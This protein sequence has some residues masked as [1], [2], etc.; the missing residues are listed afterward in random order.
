MEFEEEEV[1]ENDENWI[2]NRSKLEEL[3]NIEN[4]HEY[5]VFCRDFDEVVD[6]ED[7]CAQ[8]ELKRLRLRLDQL[9]DLVKCKQN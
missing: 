1:E 9:I 3:F 5:K 2:E 4:S 7:L 8:E 6:A